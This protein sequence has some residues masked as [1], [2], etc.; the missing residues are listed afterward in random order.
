[1]VF[2]RNVLVAMLTCRVSLV[3][4]LCL[5]DR[6]GG[7][8]W[9]LLLCRWIVVVRLRVRLAWLCKLICAMGGLF[10]LMFVPW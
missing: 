8:M 5:R 4:R 7:S 1:M 2:R 3:N 10:R 6:L 9:W